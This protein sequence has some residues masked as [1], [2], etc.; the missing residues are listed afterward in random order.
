MNNVMKKAGNGVLATAMAASLMMGAAPMAMAATGT[1]DPTAEGQQTVEVRGLAE[2]S[3]VTFYKVADYDNGTGYKWLIDSEGLPSISN[4]TG[5]LGSWSSEEANKIVSRAVADGTI[6]TGTATASGTS[7]TAKFTTGQRGLWAATVKNGGDATVVYQNMILAVNGT[8]DSAYVDVKK[9]DV[10]VSKEA[11]DKSVGVDETVTFDITSTEPV[12]NTGSTDRTY[13]ITDTL[14]QGLTFG[15]V[16]EVSDGAQTFAEGT[17]Y[18]VSQDGQ[19]VTVSFTDA[20][21]AK[22]QAG[23]SVVTKLTATR[24]AGFDGKLTNTVDLNFSDDSYTENTTTTTDEEAPVYDFDLDI[25][26]VAAGA[27]KTPLAGAKF[28]LKNTTANKYVAA[29]GSLSDTPV[30]LSVDGNGKLSVKGLDEASYELTETAAPDGYIITNSPI[31]FAVSAGYEGQA[32]TSYTITGDKSATGTISDASNLAAFDVENA[33]QGLLPQT[34]EAGS[35]AIMAIGTGLVAFAVA[36]TVRR[37][38]K[39]S[40]DKEL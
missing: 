8:T 5:D 39:K 9:S 24:A 1:G 31:A 36:V 6:A 29:D 37:R 4:M 7:G 3:Q 35:V 21:I 33:K 23:N 16:T 18:T 13:K 32:L 28:T 40:E 2:G 20:G 30:E 38:A 15:E 22:F 12:Y 17:D 34:G 19:K 10:T 26:K 27:E 14:P 25:T 11:E